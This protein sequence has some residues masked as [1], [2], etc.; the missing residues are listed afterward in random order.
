[1]CHWVFVAKSADGVD[2]R[3]ES[4]S[5]EHVTVIQQPNGNVQFSDIQKLFG[6]G[7]CVALDVKCTLSVRQFFAHCVGSFCRSWPVPCSMQRLLSDVAP[8]NT[9]PTHQIA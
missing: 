1:M 4:H 5:I 6:C 8:D 7:V 9:G 3:E 2:V